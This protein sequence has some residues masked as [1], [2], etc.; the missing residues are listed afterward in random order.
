M[1]NKYKVILEKAKKI[2]AAI[3]LASFKLAKLNFPMAM[4]RVFSTVLNISLKLE[5]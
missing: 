3:S 4:A 1:F 5:R 2:Q